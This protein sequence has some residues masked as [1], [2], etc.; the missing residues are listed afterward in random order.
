[1]KHTPGP[2]RVEH[3]VIGIDEG[4]RVVKG[5]GRRKRIVALHFHEPNTPRFIVAACNHHEELVD[6][7][8]AI[9]SCRPGCI[10]IAET[11]LSKI[12]GKEVTE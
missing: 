3:A 7:L 9:A 1:M 4:W 6:A 5:E 11:V 10:E 12:G 8:K 2:W